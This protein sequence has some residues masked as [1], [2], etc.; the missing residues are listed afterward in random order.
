[1]GAILP[2][3]NGIATVRIHFR[4][5]LLEQNGARRPLTPDP[6][7]TGGEG[8]VLTPACALI[9]FTLRPFVCLPLSLGGRGVGEFAKPVSVAQR[10]PSGTFTGR[11]ASDCRRP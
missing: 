7:P 4:G 5:D 10:K 11:A 3:G 2:S 1:M 9:S 6:S 8:R